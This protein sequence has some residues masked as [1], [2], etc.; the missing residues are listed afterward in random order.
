LVIGGLLAGRR[1]RVTSLFLA[2]AALVMG[3]SGL[4]LAVARL[5][6]WQVAVIGALT[7]AWGAFQEGVQTVLQAEAKDAIGG[8]VMGFYGAV[9]GAAGLLGKPCRWCAR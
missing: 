5:L 7:I 8:T 1:K 3:M 4:L 9:I 2:A 6:P